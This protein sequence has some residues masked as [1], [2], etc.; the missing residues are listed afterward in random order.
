MAIF[1]FIDRWIVDNFGSR[2]SLLEHAL[3]LLRYHFG[4]MRNLSKPKWK[5]VNRLVFVCH[6]NIC[7]SPYAEV[8][9]RK[10]Y[11][12]DAVSLGLKTKTGS[13]ANPFAVKNAMVRGYDLSQHRAQNISDFHFKDGDLLIGME[14]RHVKAL[15][16]QAMRHA[17][18]MQVTLLGIWSDPPRPHIADPYGREEAYFRTCFS[19]IDSAVAKLAAY[20]KK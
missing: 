4:L 8:V 18:S 11:G 9:A 3:Q 13:V 19:V 20:N 17:K 1:K 5:S 16:A 15:R 14:S 2:R 12:I 10:K 6:G 7:R